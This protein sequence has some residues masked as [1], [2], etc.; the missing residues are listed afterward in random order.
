MAIPL[1]VTVAFSV[2]IVRMYTD[3]PVVVPSAAPI[4]NSS[5]MYQSKLLVSTAVVFPV[6]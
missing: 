4:F 5:M 6:S 1:A 3:L 2:P